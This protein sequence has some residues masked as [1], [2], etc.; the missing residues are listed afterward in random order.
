MIT[1]TNLTL[2]VLEYQGQ[3]CSVISTCFRINVTCHYAALFLTGNNKGFKTKVSI[4]YNVRS[5][6]VF[7]LF[8]AGSVMVIW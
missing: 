2:L 1:T 3:K 7:C 6:I 4:L 5:P 8:S